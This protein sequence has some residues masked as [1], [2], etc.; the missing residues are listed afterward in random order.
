MDRN[1]IIVDDFNTPFTSMDRSSRQKISKTRE[2]LNDTIE[3]LGLNDIFKTLHQK[4]KMYI[5]FKCTWNV[6]KD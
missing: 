5:L 3:K 6:I 1:T 2:I 4:K